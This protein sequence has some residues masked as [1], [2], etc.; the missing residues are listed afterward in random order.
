[1]IAEH[2]HRF[3]ERTWRRPV[4]QDELADYLQAYRSEREAGEKTADAYRVAMQGV[5]TARQFIYL[6]EGEPVAR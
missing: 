4:K 1:M 5:L 2:L 6:V 3:A